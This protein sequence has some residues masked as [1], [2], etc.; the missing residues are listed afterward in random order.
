[1][2]KAT[3][4]TKSGTEIT[5]ESDRRTINDVIMT[6]QRREQLREHIN[7]D[8]QKRRNEMIHGRQK[9]LNATDLILK[10]EHEG[11]FKKTRTLGEIQNEMEKRGYMYP[12]TTLSA[13]MLRL[14]RHGKLTRIREED[15]W[16]YEQR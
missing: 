14:L 3:I 10:L 8:F 13:V 9:P 7:E 15:K 12:Q 2:V 16:G 11:F 6:I 4:K 1:M 5:I